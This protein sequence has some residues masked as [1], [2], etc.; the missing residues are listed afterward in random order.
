MTEDSVCSPLV[1]TVS[2]YIHISVRVSNA[3]FHSRVSIFK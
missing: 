1:P 2:V 3:N